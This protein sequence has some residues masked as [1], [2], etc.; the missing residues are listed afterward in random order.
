[1]HPRWEA[2]DVLFKIFPA[3]PSL[4]Q[5]SSTPLSSSMSHSVLQTLIRPDSRRRR[6][7]EVFLNLFPGGEITLLGA[8]ISLINENFRTDHSWT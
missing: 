7:I 3:F 8:G 4:P 6:V 2:L 5:F 1:M